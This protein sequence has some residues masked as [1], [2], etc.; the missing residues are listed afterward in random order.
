MNEFYNPEMTAEELLEMSNY[1]GGS[2]G[3][4][5]TI[6]L[7]IGSSRGEPHGNRI[8]VSNIPG[9][10]MGS[11]KNCFTIT[12]PDLKIV[13]NVNTSHITSKKLKSIFG[14]IKL[15]EELLIDFCQENIDAIEFAK[16][17]KKYYE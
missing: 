13:G 14:F 7:W 6:V 4:D 11:S 12:I 9:K 5:D 16:R 3:L 2:L 8:K 17:L 10:S 15:N 1:W